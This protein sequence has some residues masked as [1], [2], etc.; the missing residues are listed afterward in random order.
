MST[1]HNKRNSKAKKIFISNK[2]SK[3]E[4]I[5]GYVKKYS[6]PIQTNFFDHEKWRED[7]PGIEEHQKR[8]Q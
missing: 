1:S 2:H 8:K 3:Q 5:P 7:R 6:E 4:R